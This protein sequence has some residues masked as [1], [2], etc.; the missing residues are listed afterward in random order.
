MDLL[1]G[2]TGLIIF[3]PLL[4]AV[5]I[6]IKLN[7]RGPCHGRYSYA[8]WQKRQALQNVQIPFNGR[9]CPGHASKESR[10]FKRV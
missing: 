10:R 8:R 1:V 3:S 9:R 6:A 5:A 2:L 7:S 4:L